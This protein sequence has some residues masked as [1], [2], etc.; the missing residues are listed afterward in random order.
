MEGD[1]SVL[2]IEE[3][4]TV[5]VEID[6]RLDCWLWY[7]VQVLEERIL[8]FDPHYGNKIVT[9]PYASAARTPD[10]VWHFIGDE[11]QDFTI[12]EGPPP[13][14][15]ALAEEDEWPPMPEL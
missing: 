14:P 2:G 5:Q 11:Y 8:I 15:P 3:P 4:H 1:A 12:K 10:G 9:Y 7:M 13:D 6:G